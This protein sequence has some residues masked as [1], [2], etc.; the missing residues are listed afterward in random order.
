MPKKSRAFNRLPT[1]PP[2]VQPHSS[3]NATPKAKAA[4]PPLPE[5]IQAILPLIVENLAGRQLPNTEEQ[6][7]ELFQA[8]VS[9]ATANAELAEA[10]AG[11]N[12]EAERLNKIKMEIDE[13]IVKLAEDVTSFENKLSKHVADLELD[14]A[15]GAT[16]A[17]IDEKIVYVKFLSAK[18]GIAMRAHAKMVA[19]RATI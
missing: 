15:T 6:I 14:K 18:Y 19:Y 8:Y 3:P 4:Y 17:D 16:E 1:P 9:L 11:L 13:S 12:M 10:K 7:V 2:V 5:A